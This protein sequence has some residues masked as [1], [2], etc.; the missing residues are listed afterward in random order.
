MAGPTLRIDLRAI[1]PALVLAVVVLVIIFVELCGREDVKPLARSDQGPPP[2]LGPT[3]T[4]GPQP[5]PGADETAVPGEAT[6]SPGGDAAG[7]DAQRVLDLAA[8]EQALAD[9]REENGDYPDTEGSIQSLCVFTDFDKGC[10][11]QDVLDPL[12]QDPLGDPAANGYWYASDGDSFV[13][14]AQRETDSV[15]ECDE[16]PDHL[17]D[18]DSLLCVESP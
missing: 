3:F 1:L 4:P 6:A 10:D 18:F 2:T 5:T 12:P 8:V 14:Y 15:P 7:R 13:V 17:Q 9:F 16:H 11:L